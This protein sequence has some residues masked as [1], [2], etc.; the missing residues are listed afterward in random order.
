MIRS[1]KKQ[2]V[3]R[4]VLCAA[5]ALGLSGCLEGES[6]NT[7]EAVYTP[8]QKPLNVIA[9][10]D[11]EVKPGDTVNL[12]SRLVGTVDGQT[13]LWSQLG[14]ATIDITEPTSSTISFEIPASILSDKLVFQVAVLDSSGAQ[15]MNSDGDPLVDVVEVTVFDPES[16]ITLDVSDA[17]TVLSGASLV[18]EG[19]EAYVAGANNETHTADLAPG[20]SVVFNI[21]ANPGFYTF[22][23]RYV[24]PSDYG[25]KLANALVN[26]VKYEFALD[27][28]GQ[29]AEFRVGIVKLGEGDNT[30]EVG[31]GWGYY[32]IDGISLIPA[33]QPSGP[34]PVEGDLVNPDASAAALTLM[35][36]LA[37]NYGT[38]T[39]SGQTEFPNKVGDTFPLTEFDKIVTATGDDAPAIV[40]FD[41]M[42]YSASY[43]GSDA[44]GL[45]EAMITAHTDKNV[46]L[47]A[48]FHWR[49][50]SGNTGSGDGSF[51]TA[52]TTF[53]LSAALADTNSAEYAA[54][55]ADIDTVAL[56]LKKLADADIP[57]LWRPLHEAQGGWFWWGAQGPEALKQLWVLMYERMTDMHGLDNLIWVFTHTQ[58]MSEEW[59]PGDAHVD[60]VGYD[61]YAEPKNDATNTFASQYTTLMNRHNSEKLVALTETGTIPNVALMHEQRAWWSFFITW[62]SE[63]WNSSSVIGPQGAAAADIDANYAYENLINL[64]DIPGGQ[65]KIEA[66]VYASFDVSTAGFEAQLSWSPT[67]GITTSDI[68]ATSGS[69]SLSLLKDLSAEEAPT[70]VILQTYPVGG[71]DVTD[72]ST[73]RVSAHAINSGVNTTIKLWAKDGDGVW[74][75][76]GAMAVVDGGLELSIDVSDIDV[77]QGFG[78][79]IANFDVSSTAAEFYLDNV[80]IDDAVIFDFEPATSGFESQVN[81]SGTSGLTVTNDWAASGLRALALYKDLSEVEDINTVVLQTYP[82]GGIDVAGVSMLKVSAHAL[83]A[84]TATT[85]KLWAKDGEGVWRDAGPSVIAADG[86]ELTI[87]VS[88]LDVLQGF[89]LQIENFDV[90][91]TDAKFYLDNVRLDDTVLFDFEGTENWEFQVNWT[92]VAGIQLASDWRVSGESSMS[93]VTQLVDGD[94]NIILQTYPAGGLTLGAVTTLKATVYAMHAGDAVTAQLWIKDQDG[95]WRDEG[96]V[97]VTAEGVE[98]SVDVSDLEALQGLGVRFQGAVNS[99]SES[100]YYIDNV[101]FE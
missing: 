40:A 26:G 78:L 35:E 101:V 61:G 19:D 50:P 41:Y 14:G 34:L 93:G 27:A 47:S 77:L 23:V 25:G 62:N 20:Q 89:G 75:D 86:L 33:A 42:N 46:I 10:E 82:S 53:D 12:S 49:A 24:I 32:R 95:T 96:A 28:T 69:R 44:T 15:V 31:G 63:T 97:A 79:E 51:Y 74:R 29:W 94:D 21:D 39:L 3:L 56:E 88:D 36:Y 16:V 66:G 76:A 59:Y 18:V 1:S 91:S 64:A 99:D 67:T 57:V 13:V 45:T 22:S 68:W 11:V 85:I 9:P 98:L 73:L 80:R 92:P 100:Q 90:A 5:I 4:A 83:D 17:T 7:D 55:L 70:N 71:I 54:L 72:V 60:I 81:W 48:L 37:A 38:A 30:I 43:A 6:L 8:E 58:S 84:G 52:D 65:A 87:D 2:S